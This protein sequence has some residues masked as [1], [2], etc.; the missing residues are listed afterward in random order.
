MCPSSPLA[1][2]KTKL[3]D[4]DLD[5]FSLRETG[6]LQSICQRLNPTGLPPVTS[7]SREVLETWSD[8]DRLLWIDVTPAGILSGAP[9]AAPS[10]RTSVMLA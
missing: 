7:Y 4:A 2:A 1:F 3:V 5:I 9:F 8:G 6:H 10:L